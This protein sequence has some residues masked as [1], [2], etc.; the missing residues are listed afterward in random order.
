MEAYKIYLDSTAVVVKEYA[1][2]KDV[3]RFAQGQIELRRDAQFPAV[4]AQLVSRMGGT[5]IIRALNT[6]FY[7]GAGVA[8]AAGGDFNVLAAALNS[9]LLEPVG[10]GGGSI[11]PPT[12]AL[13]IQSTRPVS[14]GTVAAGAY[15]VS[16]AASNNYAGN[17]NGVAFDKNTSITYEG[18]AFGVL[19]AIPYTVTSGYLRI[20]QIRPV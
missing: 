3:Y 8:Y 4:A 17:V 10:T 14:G 6:Q 20:D 18:G 1:S 13:Q 15:S 19:P 12:L 9:L 16:F 5:M 7:N 11:T 2:G